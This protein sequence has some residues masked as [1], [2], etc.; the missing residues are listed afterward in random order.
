MI[1]MPP[2]PPAV[3]MTLA[4]AEN[5]SRPAPASEIA[6]APAA[7]T[8]RRSSMRR[9]MRISIAGFVIGPKTRGRRDASL[10][11]RGRRRKS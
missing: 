1:A 10:H 2:P 4:Q 7:V 6:T 5:M 9:A 11:S 3:I 8:D